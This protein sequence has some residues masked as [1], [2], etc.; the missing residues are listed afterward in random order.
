MS[1]TRY[2]PRCG[3]P[4]APGTRI[5]QVCEPEP[6]ET[7]PPAS[8]PAS[9]SSPPPSLP[10]A[11][12]G[13]PRIANP[14]EDGIITGLWVGS[15][16]LLWVAAGFGIGWVF[17]E[18]WSTIIPIIAGGLAGFFFLVAVISWIRGT[19]MRQGIYSLLSSQHL[20][21]HWHY[22]PD[23][24]RD[25]REVEW[26]ETKSDWQLQWGCMTLLFMLIGVGV[27]AMLGFENRKI[28]EAVYGG[29]MGAGGGI[30]FGGTVG[31]AIAGVNYSLARRN[32]RQMTP[33]QVAIG[34][35]AFFANG[36]YFR[37]NGVTRYIEKVKL[38]TASE[39]PELQIVVYH[40]RPKGSDT[41]TWVIVVPPRLAEEVEAIIPHINTGEMRL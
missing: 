12:P 25:M 33:G 3:A 16:F 20:L 38:D 28:L 35:N 18:S 7:P 23:E 22:T 6:D 41:Q 32:H 11:S 10:P 24:W 19:L 21:I 29:L 40:P 1:K 27:G 15:I 17:D 4:F 30:L 8:Q 36:K 9:P 31:G 39:P 14:H 5:C 34:R 37:S 13:Q 2:C 26:Q